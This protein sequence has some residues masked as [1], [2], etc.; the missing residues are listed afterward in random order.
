MNTSFKPTETADDHSRFVYLRSIEAAEIAELPEEALESI[1]N[2]SELVVVTN[3]EGQKLA[4]I[5]G[6][7]AAIAAA[8]A[9]ELQPLSLH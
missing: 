8:H 5:E 2:L 3:G 7:D 6:H 1:S 9:Y 4:I